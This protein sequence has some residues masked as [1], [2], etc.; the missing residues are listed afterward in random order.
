[1]VDLTALSPDQVRGLLPP[2]LAGTVEP[3]LAPAI[4]EAVQALVQASSDAEL[5]A[6]LR[7]MGS[8]GQACQPYPADPFGRRLSRAYMARLVAEGSTVEGMHHLAAALQAGPT[9]LL[10]N[11]RSYVDTQ[12]TDLLLAR[13]DPTLADRL[14]TVAGPKV[15]ADPFRRIA[16]VGLHT[17]KTAQSTTVAS[18]EAVLSV[19]EVAR[20]AGET[21]RQAQALMQGGHAVLL[22]PEGTR[23][24]DGRLGPFLRGAGRY[25]SLP[26]TRVLPVALQGSEA[27][28]PIGQ[29]QLQAG[30][31][32]LRL[33]EA[34]PA[35]GLS[36]DAVLDEARG[37]LD[38][39][40]SR[41]A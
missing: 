38:A 20:I 8:V 13:V 5:A 1:M 11:H 34:F 36:R 3:A 10:G 31:V 22:Y 35:D 14:V 16:A 7:A 18:E 19:R 17:I 32:H 2:W 15:Y 40:L 28:F 39:L 12:L 30:R 29:A 26:G 25:A 23:S 21:V 4:Q 41:G 6:A 33:G 9:L 27:V 24:R 37:R